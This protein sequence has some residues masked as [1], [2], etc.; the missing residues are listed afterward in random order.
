MQHSY[1]SRYHSEESNPPKTLLEHEWVA[2][3]VSTASTGFQALANR[4]ALQLA[5]ALQATSST[6]HGLFRISSILITWN[7]KSMAMVQNNVKN[8]LHAHDIDED[9]IP[10]QSY[11][12]LKTLLNTDKSLLEQALPGGETGDF[13]TMARWMGGGE[14][15]KKPKKQKKPRDP[16]APKRPVT[17]FFLYLQEN[18][19]A[20]ARE[21]PP[22]TKPGDVQARNRELWNDL[23]K[24]EQEVRCF[25]LDLGLENSPAG[26]T[27]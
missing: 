5:E 22:D 10:Q 17:A 23:S 24:D 20:T 6:S 4:K 9:S 16:N 13:G 1:P 12:H 25:F 19:D 21:M 7:N 8:A 26:L 15:P 11:P 3:R 14:A 18:K 27:C 2:R